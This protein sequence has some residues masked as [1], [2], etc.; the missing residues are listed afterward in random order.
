[1]A[2]EYR[3]PAVLSLFLHHI[4]KWGNG[5]HILNATFHKIVA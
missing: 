3:F 5:L 2:S 4:L 1:M